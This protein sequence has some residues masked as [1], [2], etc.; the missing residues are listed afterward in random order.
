MVPTFRR[1]H[2]LHL[3]AGSVRFLQNVGTF[4]PDFT[5]TYA[6]FGVSTEMAS[7]NIPLFGSAAVYSGRT[8][9]TLVFCPEAGSNRF[10]Q[11]VGNIYHPTQH[12]VPG[13]SNLN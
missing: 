12:H 13:K 4:P 10:H 2:C 1:Q 3:D 9:P 11:N 6:R 5:A 8:L 7:E